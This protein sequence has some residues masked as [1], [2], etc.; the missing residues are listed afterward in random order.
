[1]AMSKGTKSPKKAVKK[2]AAPMV[3][4]KGTKAPAKKGS[5][6]IKGTKTPAKK[7]VAKKK[8]K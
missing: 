4:A 6:P 3:A 1:M 7:T 2:M 5:G 8:K